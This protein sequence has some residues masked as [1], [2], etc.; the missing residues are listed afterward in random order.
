MYFFIVSL[1]WAVASQ[2]LKT[3]IQCLCSALRSLQHIKARFPLHI[4]L[5]KFG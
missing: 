4:A 3:T 1:A 2:G 5:L